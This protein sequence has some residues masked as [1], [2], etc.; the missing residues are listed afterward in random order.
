MV[1]VT[2]GNNVHRSTLVVGEDRTLRSLLEEAEVDYTRGMT[3]LDG[4]TVG[5]AE[6]DKTLAQKGYDGSENHDKAF[7]L[8]VVKADNA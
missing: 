7:L 4:S 5:G 1:K 6:L 3:T 2:V 8:N